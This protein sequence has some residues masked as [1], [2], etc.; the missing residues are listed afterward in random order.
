MVSLMKKYNTVIFDL[1]G[2]LLDTL[3]DLTDSLNYALGKYGLPGRKPAEVRSFVGN[4]VARLVELAIPG[5]RNHPHYGSCLADFRKHY[6]E[7]MQNKT[8]PYQG[9]RELLEELSRNGFKLGI[10]SNKFDQAVKG[11]NRFYF[12]AYVKV[13]IG[14]SPNIQRK[15]APDT[16]LKALAELGATA[17][18]AVYVGDSEVDVKT[19]HNSGLICVGATWGFRDRTVLEREGADYIIDQPQELLPILNT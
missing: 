4:G 6:A 16:V 1:D 14:E 2:T 11:L 7:N 8:M 10:V 17:N 19:A 13:A 18:Q 15:P 5:G 12:G 9:I 3:A